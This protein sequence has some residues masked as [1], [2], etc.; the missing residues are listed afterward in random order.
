MDDANERLTPDEVASRLKEQLEQRFASGSFRVA[1][2][3]ILVRTEENEDEITLEVEPLP[4][5]A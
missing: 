5:T 3:G 4:E 1:L 2:R